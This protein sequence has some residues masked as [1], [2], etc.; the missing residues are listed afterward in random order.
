[1]KQN[2]IN[3]DKARL[4]KQL[5]VVAVRQAKLDAQTAIVSQQAG[6]FLRQLR[7][8]AR[9]RLNTVATAAELS[10]ARLWSLEQATG[11]AI[12]PETF[13]RLVEVVA[14]RGK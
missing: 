7:K 8:D 12:D 3:L 4:R 2:Q 10:V 13:T 11:K 5:T 9:L 14:R 6:R 1:M